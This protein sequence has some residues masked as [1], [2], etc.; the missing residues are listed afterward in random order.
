VVFENGVDEAAQRFGDGR[1][2]GVV[3]DEEVR[4]AFRTE[5]RVTG[6]ARL[7]DA[8]RGPRWRPMGTGTPSGS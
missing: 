1:A 6:A 3:A 4:E 5:F 7:G 2:V 8:G